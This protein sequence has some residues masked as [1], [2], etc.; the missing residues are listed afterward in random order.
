[1]GAHDG[2]RMSMYRRRRA[3]WRY[4]RHGLVLVGF[5][6][7]AGLLLVI[8]P[9]RLALGA[10][11]SPLVWLLLLAAPLAYQFLSRESGWWYAPAF[12]TRARRRL[13]EMPRG[14]HDA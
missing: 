6:A 8:A 14:S 12:A 4:S 10:G 5:V 13:D 9:A 1:M 2:Y 11:V 7:V 3:P